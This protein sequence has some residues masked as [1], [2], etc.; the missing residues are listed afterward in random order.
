[1]SDNL[2]SHFQNLPELEVAPALHQRIMSRVARNRLSKP[3]VTMFGVLIANLLISGVRIWSKTIELD[4]V[5]I[6]KILFENFELDT[7]YLLDLGRSLIELFPTNSIVFFMINAVG[8]GY[9]LHFYR[10]LK[11]S[12]LNLLP[13]K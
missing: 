12:T 6:L 3:F 7:T 1:M 8:M 2:A 10:T 9:L 5:A 4:A 11:T 13:D